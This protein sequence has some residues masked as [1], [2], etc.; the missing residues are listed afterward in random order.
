VLDHGESAEIGGA[1]LEFIHGHIE[2][3]NLPN[4]EKSFDYIILVDVLEHLH[5]PQIL[6]I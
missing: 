2:D 4:P 3:K 6:I 5:N 1:I